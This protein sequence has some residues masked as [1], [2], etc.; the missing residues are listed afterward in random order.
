MSV[1]SFSPAE[2]QRRHLDAT[3]TC[4]TAIARVYA[5][6]L[7]ES[8]R[9][10]HIASELAQT[11]YGAPLETLSAKQRAD[12]RFAG[13]QAVRAVDRRWTDAALARAIERAEAWMRTDGGTAFR[14]LTDEHRHALAVNLA[15]VALSGYHQLTEGTLALAPGEY[16]RIVGG[17]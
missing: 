3:F 16:L 15:T 2:T 5:L 11:V 9:A 8:E 17:K 6:Q 10:G 13:V 4:S 1:I 12:C 14:H 7:E